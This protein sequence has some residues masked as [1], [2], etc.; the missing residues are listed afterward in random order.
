ME[1]TESSTSLYEQIKQ[2]YNETLQLLQELKNERN[3][4]VT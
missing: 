2:S 3:E 1:K 4:A